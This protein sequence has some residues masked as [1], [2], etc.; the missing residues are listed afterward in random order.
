VAAGHAVH[1]AH[2]AGEASKLHAEHHGAGAED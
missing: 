2:H 1:A